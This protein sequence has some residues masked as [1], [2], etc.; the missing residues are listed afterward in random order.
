MVRL[1]DAFVSGLA[2]ITF[3]DRQLDRPISDGPSMAWASNNACT[4]AGWQ[5]RSPGP[6]PYLLAGKVK[7]I[8][9]VLPKL[10]CFSSAPAR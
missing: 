5:C 4:E 6:I 2:F 9:D 10:M 8:N 1:R 3:P 7:A